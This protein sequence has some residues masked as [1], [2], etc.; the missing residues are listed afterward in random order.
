MSQEESRN[1]LLIGAGF[2]KNFGGYLAEDVFLRIFNH[3]KMTD[4]LRSHLLSFSAHAT[5]SYNFEEFYESLADS[6][7][8]YFSVENKELVEYIIADIF[9]DMD[10]VFQARLTSDSSN[11]SYLSLL[12]FLI[13]NFACTT[14]GAGYIFSLNQDLLLERLFADYLKRLNFNKPAGWGGEVQGCLLPYYGPVNSP[15]Y[16]YHKDDSRANEP[17]NNIA[18][19]SQKEIDEWL[20]Q[21]QSTHEKNIRDVPCLVKLHGSLYWRDQNDKA[22]AIFGVASKPDKIESIPMTKLYFDTFKR[23]L[24]TKKRLCVIGYSFRDKHINQLIAASCKIG[25]RLIVIDVESFNPWLDKIRDEFDKI[26]IPFE[27]SWLKAYH[28]SSFQD[29]FPLTMYNSD[30][31]FDGNS[32][33]SICQLRQFSSFISLDK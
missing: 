5:G 4:E 24:S 25:S 6:E 23:I 29:L 27:L 2:S 9:T 3:P 7:S 22:V 13:N 26:G 8:R 30:F 28:K 18:T 32:N 31:K 10:N 17:F 20:N 12:S 33:N 16:K 19:V 21:H 15:F 14:Q 11:F 1:V